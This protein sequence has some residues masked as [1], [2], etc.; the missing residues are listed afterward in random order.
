MRVDA[1]RS[2][3]RAAQH[4]DEFVGVGDG[5]GVEA[6]EGF[7]EQDW[8]RRGCGSSA[9]EKMTRHVLAVASDAMIHWSGRSR[10]NSAN[11][12]LSPEHALGY[13]ERTTF[14]SDAVTRIRSAS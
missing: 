12:F 4:S 6:G 1:E 14:H 10:A 2:G 8:N 11:P 7:V 3:Q 5:V 9:Y 13:E